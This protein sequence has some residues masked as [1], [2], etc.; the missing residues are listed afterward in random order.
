MVSGDIVLVPLSSGEHAKIDLQDFD[1]AN[2]LLWYRH[3]ASGYV[4]SSRAETYLH[5]KIMSPPKGMVVDH[6]NG[7]VLD[8]R[9]Q[10]LRV[11]FH[12]QNIKNQKLSRNNSTG[13]KG[14]V[15]RGNRFEASIVSDKKRYYLGTF[16]TLD[17]ASIAYAQA[18]L[19]YHGDFARPE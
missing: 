16:D 7:D 6:I 19:K 13:S 4:R 11:C 12:Y 8:N 15:R 3:G 1:K 5:R 18:C 2:G 17:Q 14:V 9:R 10:N